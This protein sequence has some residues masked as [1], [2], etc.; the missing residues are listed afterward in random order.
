VYF[1]HCYANTWILWPFNWVSCN[2]HGPNII[3]EGRRGIS[4]EGGV[5]YLRKGC[6]ISEEGGVVYLRREARSIWGRRRGIFEK[7]GKDYLSK[8]AWSICWAWAA[9]QRELSRQTCVITWLLIVFFRCEKY[10]QVLEYWW[11]INRNSSNNKN[12][13]S[14]LTPIPIAGFSMVIVATLIYPLLIL[15]LFPLLI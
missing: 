4:E 11:R 14:L 7:G 2:L 5:V 3:W 1:V 13:T 12:D 10:A 15:S 9:D 6:G 8:E